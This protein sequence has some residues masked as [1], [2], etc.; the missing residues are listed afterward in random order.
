MK[1]LYLKFFL[2]VV[3]ILTVINSASGKEASPIKPI[4]Q[5]KESMQEKLAK[6]AGVVLTSKPRQS[7]PL[8][9]VV[10]SPEFK[11]VPSFDF[12]PRKSRVI[13]DN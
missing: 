1:G 13:G 5:V 9:T 7:S 8:A 11:R 10:P 2:S 6:K 12:V 3:F 4:K